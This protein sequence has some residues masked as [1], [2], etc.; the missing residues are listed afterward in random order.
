MVFTG[1][2]R[3]G[4]TAPT[5]HPNPLNTSSQGNIKWWCCG[6]HSHH[7]YTNTNLDPYGAHHGLLWLHVRWLLVKPRRGQY[8]RSEQERGHQ[9]AAPLVPVPHCGDGLCCSDYG[10]WVW[11]GQLEGRV[12]VCGCY[13]A[14]VC[15]S[16]VLFLLFVIFWRC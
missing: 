12:C 2:H 8:Q 13:A 3:Y 5:M 1:Y 15:S 4:L 7:R 14:V 9:V 16:C 6:H 11:L 10:L